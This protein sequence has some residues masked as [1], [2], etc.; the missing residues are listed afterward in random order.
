MKVL[1]LAMEG[2]KCHTKKKSFIFN[3]DENNIIG[4]NFTGKTTISEGIIWG[5]LGTNLY[6]SD[7]VDSLFNT[8]S[9]R[10]KVELSFEHNGQVH[11]ITRYKA[12][13][14][15]T[16]EMDGKKVSQS[17]IEGMLHNKEVI[18][19]S[20]LPNYFL[21]MDA[22]AAREL[23]ISL[24]RRIPKE[25]V[26]KEFS[27]PEQEILNRF[28]L[29]NTNELLKDLRKD[30]K[31]EKEYSIELDG[32]LQELNNNTEQVVPEEKVFDET[33][34][35]SL[36]NQKAAMENKQPE[37]IDTS[38]VEREIANLRVKYEQTKAKA[39]ETPVA[40]SD[41]CDR[42][43][44]KIPE[45][46]RKE[47]MDRYNVELQQVNKHNTEIESQLQ[48]IAELGKIK[49]EELKKLKAENEKRVNSFT[50]PDT[51]EIQQ[52][53]I[54]LTNRK[55]EV[56]N[57]NA[58]RKQ[59]I[60]SMELIKNRKTQIEQD[61]ENNKK[62]IEN[63][64]IEINT[65]AS[66][67]AKYAEV[68]IKQLEPHLDRASIKLY[69]VVKSTGELKPV[70]KVLY[71]EKKQNVLSNSERIRCGIELSNLICK[72]AEV[73]LPVFIDNAEGITEFKKPDRQLFTATVVKGANLAVNKGKEVA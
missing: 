8:G 20:F 14:S 71:D 6:G 11:E 13:G 52:R 31:Q 70:F 19:S 57:H 47:V 26:I 41:V 49:S 53:I 3:P 16:I 24:M 22:K 9:K 30:L 36:I 34:L 5:L 1:S 67:A 39:K 68:Q 2:F 72:L 45:S 35:T 73:D 33:E 12:K 17:Q 56:L 32:R 48:N 51:S 66:Y 46:K 10:M 60:E 7:R 43:G 23:L 58:R 62:A 40:P 21:S 55:N 42:C 50:V 59:I 27:E 18:L 65:V 29:Y 69:D 28:D 64:T 4:D 61:I 54:D 15:P 38:E 37:L 25:E 44:Q 63:L